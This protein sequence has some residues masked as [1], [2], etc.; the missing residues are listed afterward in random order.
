MPCSRSSKLLVH[1]HFRL[2]LKVVWKNDDVIDGEDD[3]DDDGGDEDDEDDDEKLFERPGN[4]F[5]GR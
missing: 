1:R 5:R 2:A 4:S 3:D